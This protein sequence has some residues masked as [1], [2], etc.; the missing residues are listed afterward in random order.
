[1]DFDEQ[2]DSLEPSDAQFSRPE[3]PSRP[4][5]AKRTS[6]WRILGRIIFVLSVL[7]NIV[8][9]I[10]LIGLAVVFVTGRRSVLLEKVIQAGPRENKIVVVNVEGILDAQESRQ[11]CEQIKTAGK[12]K[13]VKAIILRVDSPGGTVSASDQ[14][15]NEIHKF[16][17]SGKPAVAFMQ[18]VAASGGYY[19]SVAC[20][21]IIAEP[22]VITGSIGVIMQHFVFQE[23]FE[24]KLGIQPV[25]FKSGAKKDWPNLFSPV[26]EEQKQYL[27]KRLMEPAYNRFVELVA[28]GREMLTLDEVQHLADGGIFSAEQ[29]LAEKLIDS[30][31]Y[32]DDA[33]ELTKELAGIEAA[34]VVEYQRPFS[35]SNLLDSQS[36][37]LFQ[38]DRNTLHELTA[39][40]LLYLWSIYE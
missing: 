8:L 5:K 35:L 28:E 24:D 4:I 39:P 31:G 12:D 13:N 3:P 19:T 36:R 22:T 34:H 32:L 16:R 29:A 18:R 20:E 7:A 38:I 25:T 1:M 14:I 21:K 15:H 10:L 11:V 2:N 6:V 9:V 27:E 30:I 23:L 40:Q 33:I 37:T 17:S 26:T